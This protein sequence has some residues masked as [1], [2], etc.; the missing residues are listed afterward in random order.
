MQHNH[1]C[2]S[3]VMVL[4]LCAMATGCDDPVVSQDSN[5]GA[6]AYK[7][8]AEGWLAWA[9][10]QPHSTASPILDETGEFCD[11]GQSGKVWYLA[12]TFGGPVERTCT[13]P[14]RKHLY[15]PLVN[16]WVINP[17]F[18]FWPTEEEYLAFAEEWFSVHRAHTCGLTLRLDGEDLL[19]NDLEDLDEELY[20]KQLDIFETDINPDNWATQFGFL[21]GPTPTVTDGHWA[22]L[23]PLEPGEH[24]L[25]FGGEVCEG[26]VSGFTT[27]AVY[28]LVVEE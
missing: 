8:H 23:R 4:A 16:R 11:E 2:R 26:E 17:E 27:S 6:K 5:A 25:E 20:V 24:V 1:A 28:N 12:G 7:K 13:I 15:F 21:G 19:G 3:I 14:K 18:E 9:L 22:L 10:G